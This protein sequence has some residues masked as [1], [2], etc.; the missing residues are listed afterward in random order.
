ML[1][2]FQTLLAFHHKIPLL[3]GSHF[4]V[5]ILVETA[6]LKKSHTEYVGIGETKV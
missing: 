2:H 6:S 5:V 4:L 1:T 3:W